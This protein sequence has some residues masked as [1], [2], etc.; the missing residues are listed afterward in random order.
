MISRSCQVSGLASKILEAIRSLSFTLASEVRPKNS[1]VRAKGAMPSSAP[2][3]SVPTIRLRPRALRLF[4]C[5]FQKGDHLFSRHRWKPFKKVIDRVSSLEIFDECLHENPRSAK[6]GSAA[7][8]VGI[9]T[10][11]R[12]AHV[13]NI[14]KIAHAH[15]ST[16]TLRCERSE[17][18]RAT[19]RAP[20][21]YPSRAAPRP[22]QDDGEP[23]TRAGHVF[24][25]RHLTLVPI[26]VTIQS[27]LL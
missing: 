11:N 9:T 25:D 19:A 5:L 15:P 16:V 17:P 20:R 3:Q 13:S 2:H 1:T 10:N 4:L 22:P 21:P 12:L 24:R 14:S 18:R 6:Y 23:L 8:N 27:S 26:P 7:H